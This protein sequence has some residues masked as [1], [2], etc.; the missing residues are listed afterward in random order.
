MLRSFFTLLN[1]ENWMR[2]DRIVFMIWKA[3]AVIFVAVHTM[4]LTDSDK[5]LLL[6]MKC[7][8]GSRAVL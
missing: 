1:A 2:Y 4:T 8:Y 6:N 7:M 5:L 3:N